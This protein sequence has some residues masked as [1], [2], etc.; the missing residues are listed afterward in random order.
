MAGILPVCMLLMAKM[1]SVM[2][3]PATMWPMLPLF[4]VI[5]GWSGF[6]DRCRIL[7]MHLASLL[8]PLGVLVAWQ[9]KRSMASPFSRSMPS[10]PRAWLIA[11]IKPLPVSVGLNT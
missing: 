1:L 9:L 8:S 11:V 4:A 6:W 10:T 7:L 2:A 3:A 5:I